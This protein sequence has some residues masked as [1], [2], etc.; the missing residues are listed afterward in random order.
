MSLGAKLGWGIATLFF[1]WLP[2]F[3]LFVM[4]V[5]DELED[6]KGV[7]TFFLELASLWGLLGILSL[8]LFLYQIS[9]GSQA[10]ALA[11][12]LPLFLYLNSIGSED[13]IAF[14]FPGL[15]PGIFWGVAM[16]AC[17]VWALGAVVFGLILR[18]IDSQDRG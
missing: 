14:Q 13:I 1:G 10:A 4:V 5:G 15:Q 9:F 7:G 17:T 16:W 3:V 2:M 8:I 18:N 12:A 6:R 11:G